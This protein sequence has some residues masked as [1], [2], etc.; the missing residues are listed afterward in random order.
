[1]PRYPATLVGEAAHKHRSVLDATG[2]TFAGGAL[3][4]QLNTMSFLR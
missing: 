2:R 1:M 3:D 4:L